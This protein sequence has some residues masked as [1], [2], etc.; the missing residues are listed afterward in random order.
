M[1]MGKIFIPLTDMV[2]ATFFST[3]LQ[4]KIYRNLYNH[5]KSLNIYAYLLKI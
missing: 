3:L 4:I 5:L 1:A 2:L